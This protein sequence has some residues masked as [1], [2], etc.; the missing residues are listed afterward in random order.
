MVGRM[1]VERLAG[2]EVSERQL[3]CGEHAVSILEVARLESLVDGGA[4]LREEQ[5]A[6]P[7][8]WAH[9][10]VGSRVLAE[11]VARE[12]DC[13]DRRVIDIGCGLGLPA[14]VAALGGGR[15]V[16][17]DYVRDAL[18]FAAANARRNRC[19]VEVVQFDLRQPAL[20]TEIDICLAA[21]VTY[22]PQLQEAL[23][24]FLGTHLSRDG[25]AWCVESVR[26][27]DGGFGGACVR[28]GLRVEETERRVTDDG[29]PLIV[30]VSEVSRPTALTRACANVYKRSHAQEE[31][32]GRR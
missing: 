13:R 22:D 14:V 28:Y 23:A 8:Y 17:V 5:I 18:A 20:R 3:V 25:R 16:A 30:R 21:D 10:W 19:A 31:P 2:Y 7:P 29:R 15:V 1:Q 4:L 24:S 9:L 11:I 27:V 32:A 6:E 12:I 26:T